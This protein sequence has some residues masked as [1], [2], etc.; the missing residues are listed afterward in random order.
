MFKTRR[1][2]SRQVTRA[3]ARKSTKA[4]VRRFRRKVGATGKQY[5]K[6][7]TRMKKVGRRFGF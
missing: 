1:K 7:Q 3:K 5:R 4:E 2:P 6:S